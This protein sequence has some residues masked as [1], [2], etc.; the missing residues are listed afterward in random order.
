MV[1]FEALVL[2]LVS[3]QYYKSRKI[4]VIVVFH[5]LMQI[6]NVTPDHEVISTDPAQQ[7]TWNA[8]QAL[9]W[10]A[11]MLLVGHALVSH[12]HEVTCKNNEE[13]IILRILRLSVSF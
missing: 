1:G 9:Q 7:A 12:F 10:G 2:R 5:Q 6:T 4:N 13:I 8:K 3:F 11:E